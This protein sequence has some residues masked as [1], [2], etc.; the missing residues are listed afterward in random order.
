MTKRILLTLPTVAALLLGL[1]AC[2]KPA[3]PAPAPKPGGGATPAAKP[4]KKLKIAFVSN[5]VASFW[6]IAAA[7]VKTAGEK[8]GVDAQTL[9]PVEGIGDQK[10]MIED[11]L[12]KGVDGIAVSPID[13]PPSAPSSLRT[14]RMPRA[15]TASSISAWTITRPAVSAATSCARPCPRA[16]R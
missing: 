10:R 16:A 3:E 5:G 4:G 11:L 12:T 15:A 9:M 14:T 2:N 8:F 6:T 13:P 1:T 7:G